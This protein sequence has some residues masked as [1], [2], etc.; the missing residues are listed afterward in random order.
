MS[1]RTE[2]T[3][4]V[5]YEK[6]DDGVAIVTLNRP[7]RLNALSGP[8]LD[9]LAETVEA[10]A[11]D[12]EV[13]VFLLRGVPR[14]DGRPC[15]SAG[16]DVQAFAEGRGVTEEQGFALTNRIDDLLKP[17]IAVID[18]VCTTG[19]AELAL[20]CDFRLVARTARISDWHL[21]KLGTGLGSWGAS[22]RWARE[23][24]VTN[25]KQ[26][27][28]TGR[29]IDGD[30]AFRIGF[31]S[32]VFESASLESAALDMARRIAG[33]NPDGVRL[34][35]AHLD[36]VGDMSRDQALNWAKL[37]AEWLGVGVTEAELKGKVLGRRRDDAG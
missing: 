19:G 29:E 25:A 3:A 26:M 30:E 34:T 1:D 13:R 28:L 36:R 23:C 16:V 4:P 2:S 32:G 12:P 15:F 21:A 35:L 17:S 9:A 33:M 22:T 37:S 31:A 20:A 10:I 8:L 14:P 6:R 27:L 24:G 5:L 11:R 7:A 18:G